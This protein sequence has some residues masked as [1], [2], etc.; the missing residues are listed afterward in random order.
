ML[1]QRKAPRV[2]IYTDRPGWHCRRLGAAL[3]SLGLRSTVLVPQACGIDLERPTGLRLPGFADALP[4]AVFVRSVPAGSFEQVT[5]RLTLLHALAALG[6]PVIN[7]ARMIERTVDKAM[8]SWLLHRAGVPTPATWVVDATAAAEPLSPVTRQRAGTLVC[9]PLFGAEGDGLRRIEPGD[10]WPAQAPPGHVHYMQRFVCSAPAGERA[11][12]GLTCTSGGLGRGGGHGGEEG[13]EEGA[14]DCR[15]LVVGGRARVAM[16]RVTRAGWIT[17]VARGAHPKPMA[18]DDARADLAELACRAMADGPIG[19]DYAGVDIITDADGVHRVL[20]VNGA[21]AWRG[22]QSVVDVD[23]ATLL[24]RH[25]ADR[26]A[27]TRGG[28]RAAHACT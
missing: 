27:A 2:A 1:A 16:R 21:P 18:L 4:D 22:L 25:V 8:T 26:I 10:P 12:P 6:V 11:A 24:A 3:D 13:A 19:L 14:E 23:V 15:V 28:C 17:N 7:P 5:L 20:E 9:K